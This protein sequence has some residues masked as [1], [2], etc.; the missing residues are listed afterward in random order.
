MRVLK[1][2]QETEP[3]R[4]KISRG[5]DGQRKTFIALEN[6]RKISQRSGIY[7]QAER[8]KGTVREGKEGRLTAA[9]K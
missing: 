6:N 2:R 1:Y 5:D 7:R 8:S 4:R 9:E 3:N